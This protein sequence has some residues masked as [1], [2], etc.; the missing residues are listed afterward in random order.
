M[1]HYYRSK[2]FLWNN[3]HFRLD[4]TFNTERATDVIFLSLGPFLIVTSNTT[5]V[6]VQ[7]REASG[8][9]VAINKLS[10]QAAVRVERLGDA[11]ATNF[12]VTFSVAP[13]KMFVVDAITSTANE[14]MVGFDYSTLYVNILGSALV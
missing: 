6:D 12:V 13:A 2:V 4:H 3:G 14:I 9:F 11:E 1:C 7:V 10:S 8:N 5:G